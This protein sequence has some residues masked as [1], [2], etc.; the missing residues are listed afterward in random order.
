MRVLRAQGYTKVV[1]PLRDPLARVASG[2]RHRLM[3]NSKPWLQWNKVF[4]KAFGG[5]AHGKGTEAA[6]AATAA[7]DEYVSALR[8]RAHPKHK[9]A[10]EAT[11]GPLR[12]HFMLPIAQF[13]LAGANGVSSSSPPPSSP[14]TSPASAA[15]GAGVTS[16]GA[17]P[18]TSRGAP[19][20]A[21]AEVAF[22]CVD[23]LRDDFN[24]L[25]RRWGLAAN[26]TA[27]SSGCIGCSR[28]ERGEVG[29][30]GAV[31]TAEAGGGAAAS[32]LRPV[33][34]LWKPKPIFSAANEQ[35]L[36]RVFAEDFELLREHC[37][38]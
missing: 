37:R 5:S 14:P 3:A 13:Y 28:P 16:A 27:G 38:S 4:N 15:P 10:I 7:A 17:P 19:A 2:V 18:L 11:L 12:A 34:Q 9:A 22:V 26:M 20:P 1:V 25:A 23:T 36:R 33:T 8:L 32:Q 30:R 21:K 29:A 31:A 24:A 35:W 6:E